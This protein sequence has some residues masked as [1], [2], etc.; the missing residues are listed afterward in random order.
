MVSTN[1]QIANIALAK[2]GGKQITA[3]SDNTYINNV[4][5]MILD[6]VLLEHPWTWAQTRA[7]CVSATAPTIFTGDGL[8]ILYSKPT[9]ML[10]INFVGS[11]TAILKIESNGILCNEDTLEVLY[12]SRVTDPTKYSQPF[13]SA[14][15]TRLAAE[16][17]FSITNDMKKTE[18]LIKEYE[19]YRLPHAMSV[20]SQ[21]GSSDVIKQDEWENARQ[22]GAGWASARKDADTW[23][24]FM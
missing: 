23:V 12:T 6:E 20:D 13:I 22:S 5:D 3:L 10:K 1:I 9:D 21:Q 24:P 4:Y 11:S 8:T 17:C 7:T 18:A 2:V 19:G 15:A 14:L 16:V